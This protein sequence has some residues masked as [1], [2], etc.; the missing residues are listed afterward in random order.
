[1]SSDDFIA[2]SGQMQE[3]KR[4]VNLVKGIKVNTLIVGDIGTGKSKIANTILPNAISVNGENSEETLKGIKNFN[5]MIIENFDK[6]RNYDALNLQ[7]QKIVATATKKPKDSV[8]DK[9]FGIVVELLPLSERSED[10][11]ALSECFLQEAKESLKI[12]SDT[13][14]ELPLLDISQN[15]HTLKR[16][17]FKR[18]LDDTMDEKALVTGMSDFFS[19][20]IEIDDNYSHFIKMFDTAVIMANHRKYKSQLMMSYKMGINRNTLRKKINEL[21]LKLDE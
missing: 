1:M 2:V 20:Q 6:V 19:S 9:F 21:G 3:V 16:G 17:I 18:L 7:N 11:Q 4:V 5:E 15:C 8:V 12:D 10:I 13:K 14:I